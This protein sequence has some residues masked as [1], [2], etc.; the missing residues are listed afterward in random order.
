M[1]R[2]V[3][4]EEGGKSLGKAPVP[5][6]DAPVGWGRMSKFLNFAPYT[7]ISHTKNI[8]SFPLSV[9]GYDLME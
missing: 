4:T 6:G 9:D 8:R 1:Y 3:L 5:V 2:G 7:I